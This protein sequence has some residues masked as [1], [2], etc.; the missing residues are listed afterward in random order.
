MPLI[1]TGKLAGMDEGV[2]FDRVKFEKLVQVKGYD[3]TWEKGLKCP[4]LKGP[5]PLDHSVTCKV[6][7]YGWVY[8]DAKQTRMIATSLTLPQQFYAFG[9]FSAGRVQFTAFP[10]FKVSFFDRITLHNSRT[11]YQ[12]YVLR[13]RSST[14]DRT[15]FNPLCFEAIAWATSDTAY[16]VAIEGDY[17]ITESGEI[18]WVTS[19]R[20][21]PNTHYSVIYYHRPM[22]I[23]LDLTHQV[24]DL[25]TRG[26]K[27]EEFP[28]QVVAQLDQFLREEGKDPSDESDRTNPFPAK[29]ASEP[30]G[31]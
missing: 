3:V 30:Q 23:V 19:H 12:E 13:N 27:Q 18:E 28:V 20:P 29:G 25:N 24:R 6:C 16:D 10:E 22:Y 9:R 21:P 1:Q 2:P 31:A 14:K 26:G 4:F 17:I 8:I 7:T 11:R 15:T 5:N